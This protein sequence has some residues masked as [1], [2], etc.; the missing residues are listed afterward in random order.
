[1]LLRKVESHSICGNILRQ[2]GK[3]L[4]ARQQQV[5][6]NGYESASLYV[7][8]G[9]PQGSVLG[10]LLFLLFTNDIDIGVVNLISY[11]SSQMIPKWW[12]YSPVNLKYSCYT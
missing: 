2:I 10:P 7:I 1:M 6:L 12:E 4:I 11:L 5:V 9:V 8:S 3:W